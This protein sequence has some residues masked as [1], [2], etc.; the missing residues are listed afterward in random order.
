MNGKKDQR[1]GQGGVHHGADDEALA[2]L[3][4]ARRAADEAEEAWAVEAERGGAVGKEAT[5]SVEL[6]ASKAARSTS[7]TES[8]AYL[9]SANARTN[10][11]TNTPLMMNL[12]IAN[13]ER[14]QDR[15]TDI[16]SYFQQYP[17]S[18]LLFFP[19]SI[20]VLDDDELIIP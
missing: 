11:H 16:F 14:A 2:L 15:G 18:I 6:Q 20:K 9:K 5:G 19:G 12:P 3:A 1:R 17:L 4:V 7:S 8:L 10:H 13:L